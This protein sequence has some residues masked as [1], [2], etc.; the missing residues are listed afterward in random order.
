MKAREI[1]LRIHRWT[2][3][4]V[5]IAL[6]FVAITGLTMVFRPQLEPL[7]DASLREVSSCTQRLPLDAQVEKARALHPAGGIRQ[8]EISDGGFG[9]T[10]VRFADLQGYFVDPCN[11][12]ILG[13]QH[14]W[15]GFF[16]T[17]EQLHRWR[18]IDNV[19]VAETI[20]GSLALALAL[21][22]VVGGLT[23]GWPSSR[24]QWKSAFKLKL[25]LTGAAFEINLHRTIGVYASAILLSTTL[26]AQ[27]FTFEWARQLVFAVTGST[28][29]AK[30]PASRAAS[31]A[32]QPMETFLARTLETVPAARD[33]TLLYPRKPGDS[34]EAAVLERD[35]P[36]PNAKT[37][38][39][40]DAYT[41]EVLRFQPYATSSA[42]NKVYRW[43]ASL[44]MG[45]IGGIAGQVA[46]FLGV[47]AVPV[48][49][50]T[51]IRSY[52]RRRVRAPEAKFRQ[53]SA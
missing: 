50:Y 43:L 34:V 4:T 37:L 10:V 52:L 36:H 9:A 32:M 24:R 5:G 41:G 27:T 45:Y 31:G 14:R 1:I 26:A 11:G 15:G 25:R 38:V 30:K 20:A 48:L 42:G 19:D 7:V 12:A 40:L 33:I 49:G 6:I 46:L 23:V 16:N 8:L 44:H 3:L 18:F 53:Q 28:A 35:A 39:N 21:L 13:R 29:P 47:L 2:G 17:V 51:G 22:M